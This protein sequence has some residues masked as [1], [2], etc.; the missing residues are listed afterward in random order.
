VEQLAGC[1]E[2]LAG[3][4]SAER[5]QALLQQ[6]VQLRAALGSAPGAARL[7]EAAKGAMQLMEAALQE[8]GGRL[9]RDEL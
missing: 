5:L 7:A 3:L 1:I 4:P 2:D 6:A 9:A 8:V